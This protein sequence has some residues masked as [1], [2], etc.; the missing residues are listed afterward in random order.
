MMAR[1]YI[2]LL[3]WA[4]SRIC[5]SCLSRRSVYSVCNLLI[6]STIS[7]ELVSRISSVWFSTSSVERNEG[8]IVIESL[9]HAHTFYILKHMQKMTFKNICGKRRNYLWCFLIYSI[10]IHSLID[11]YFSVFYLYILKYHLL[12]VC[13]MWDKVNC[14]L[15][16]IVHFITFFPHS[17]L[18]KDKWH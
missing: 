4:L 2:Y 14:N 16:T 3:S 12:Q 1:F 8:V 6:S 5:A 10:L 9:P 17:Q 11:K 18:M 15:K 7:V 13:F